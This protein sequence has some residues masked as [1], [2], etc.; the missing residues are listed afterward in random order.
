LRLLI[1]GDVNHAM[2]IQMPYPDV[3]YARD[4]DP[5]QAIE[6]RKRTLEYL[7]ANHI[8]VAGMHIPFPGIGLVISVGNGAYAFE[9]Y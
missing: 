9:S 1:W 6:T 5:A 7:S 8:P 3:T 2:S 4:T